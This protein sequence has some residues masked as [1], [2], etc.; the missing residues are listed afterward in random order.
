MNLIELVVDNDIAIEL[1]IID[2]IVNL[3]LIHQDKENRWV[4]PSKWSFKISLPVR[5]HANKHVT[6]WKSF[7]LVVK[8]H[9]AAG[10][11]T[12]KVQR[13]VQRKDQGV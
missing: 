11:W 8:R 3:W 2:E 7:R 5:V 12:V 1:L 6:S 9:H 13:S 4:T 10:T